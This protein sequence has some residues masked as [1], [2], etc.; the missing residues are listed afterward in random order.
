MAAQVEEQRRQPGEQEAVLR[1][2]A[3]SLET[4]LEEQRVE[5]NTRLKALAKDNSTLKKQ[6]DDLHEH[7]LDLETALDALRAERS[8]V[9]KLQKRLTRKQADLDTERTKLES[10]LDTERATMQREHQQAIKERDDTLERYQAECRTSEEKCRSLIVERD[11]SLSKADELSRE[12]DQIVK[13]ATEIE[14]QHARL[15]DE[16][17]LT[18]QRIEAL[19][20]EKED[21]L[22]ERD[23]ACK[24]REVA[25]T[26]C[27]TLL[28]ERDDAL[29]RT[30]LVCAVV[31]C[32]PPS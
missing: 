20:R 13:Q 8:S 30:G 25:L 1:A 17:D 27:A 5:A 19:L 10:D 23:N 15:A 7:R 18:R 4:H 2:H 12:M 21:L 32:R 6:R 14:Q 9:Q 16:M 29:K 3:Q 22:I 26:D 11:A 28:E 31:V 24:A